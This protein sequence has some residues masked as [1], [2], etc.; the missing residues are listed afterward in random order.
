MTDGAATDVRL[1]HLR[2]VDRGLD[3]SRLSQ[4]L[5]RVLQ[6]QR[7][8]DCRQHP[9]VVGLGPVHARPGTGHPAPDVATADHD[10]DVDADALARV[11]DLV[12]HVVGDASVDP[13]ADLAR[14]RLAGD[15]QQDAAVLGA[16]GATG[17]VP[18]KTWAKATSS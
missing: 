15:L 13:V 4:P 18:M 9:H 12:S 16:H 3:S 6:S 14:E 1:S 11:D 2:H 10:C 5:E 8:D 7:V 17:Q